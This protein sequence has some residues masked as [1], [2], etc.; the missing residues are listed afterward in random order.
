MSQTTLIPAHPCESIWMA[1]GITPDHPY[2]IIS[3]SNGKKELLSILSNG[4]VK[5]SIED[6][7][8]A[9]KLFIES[10]RINGSSL[11]ERIKFLEEQIKN[12]MIKD[13][14]TGA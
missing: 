9:G 13:I 1:K 4:E 8:E 10:I 14:E 2:A 11:I 12:S 5:G 7:S 3:I 6:A